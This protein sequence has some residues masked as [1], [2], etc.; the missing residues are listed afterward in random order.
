MSN[1]VFKILLATNF[2]V[3]SISH[4]DVFNTF[5][6]SGR[7]TNSDG[8][9][10]TGSADLEINFFTSQSGGSQKGTTYLFSATPLKNGVFN[11]EI[12]IS[13]SDIPV[14]LDTSTETWIEVTDSTN[15]VTYP[16]QKLNSVP[17]AMKARLVENSATSATSSNTGESIVLRDPYGNFEVSDPISL[18]V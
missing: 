12:V 5:N 18:G 6:Y 3:A 4:A 9:P 16:R 2:L 15:S 1:Q 11:L 10:K 8:R 7:I 17:Y 14:V 13:D